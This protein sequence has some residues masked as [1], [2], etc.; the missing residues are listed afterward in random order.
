MVGV[1]GILQRSGLPADP[2]AFGGGEPLLGR[3][4]VIG[5]SD[6]QHVAA[7]ADLRAHPIRPIPRPSR[8]LDIDQRVDSVS[9]QELGELQ[10][11]RLVRR[12]VVGVRNEHPAR[13]ACRH[14]KIFHRSYL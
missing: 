8:D 10:H 14:S 2:F 13:A 6:H 4:P 1:E 3:G 7:L 12:I 9:T 5:G 11:L